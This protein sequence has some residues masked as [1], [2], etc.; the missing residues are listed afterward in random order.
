VTPAGKLE[1]IQSGYDGDPDWQTT[2]LG[3]L[4][5]MMKQK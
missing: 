2:I 5:E 1:T 4:Q 3:K